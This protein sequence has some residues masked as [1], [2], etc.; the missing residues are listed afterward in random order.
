MSLRL[1][2]ALA[3]GVPNEYGRCVKGYEW[4]TIQKPRRGSWLLPDTR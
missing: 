2:G 1:Y 3:Q 4:F